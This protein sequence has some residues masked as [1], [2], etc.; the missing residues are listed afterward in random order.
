MF[1]GEFLSR[2]HFYSGFREHPETGG[3][4]DVADN[5]ETLILELLASAPSKIEKLRFSV[6]GL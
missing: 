5:K 1:T 3:D 4:R 6:M 2:V